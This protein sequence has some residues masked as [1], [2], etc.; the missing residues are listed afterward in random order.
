M[1]RWHSTARVSKRLTNEPAAQQ[2]RAALCQH[3]VF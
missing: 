1:E 3:H 2:S